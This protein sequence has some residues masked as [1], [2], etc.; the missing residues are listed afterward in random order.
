MFKLK[1]IDHVLLDFK[2]INKNMIVPFYNVILSLVLLLEV[3]Q[4]DYSSLI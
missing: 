2:K 3:T 4:M 1:L